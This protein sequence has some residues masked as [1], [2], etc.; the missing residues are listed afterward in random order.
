MAEV[1]ERAIQAAHREAVLAPPADVVAFLADLLSQR[2]V[3]YIA[4]VK[5]TKTVRRWADNEIDEMRQDSEK[6]IRTAY[7]IAQLLIQVD[8]PRIV[9]AWF[10]GLNPQLDEAS[11]AE[12]IHEGKLKEAKYAAR[13]FIAGGG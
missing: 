9:K 13:A 5:D 10:I 6:R 1:K 4:G 11:P 2:L 3:A 8:S 12:A 7:E